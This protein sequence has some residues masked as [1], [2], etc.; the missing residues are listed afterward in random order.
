VKRREGNP[1]RVCQ[2]RKGNE[3]SPFG[4]LGKYGTQVEEAT[5]ETPP[6]T[7][8]LYVVVLKFMQSLS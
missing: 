2:S 7:G 6:A 4:R 1:Q 5:G 3:Y 8:A